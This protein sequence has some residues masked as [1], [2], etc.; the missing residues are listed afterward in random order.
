[1]RGKNKLG[2]VILQLI[3]KWKRMKSCR[4]RKK[5]YYVV[6]GKETKKKKKNENQTE[7]NQIK[8]TGRSKNKCKCRR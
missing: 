8:E 3:E 1:M 6:L 5:E 2:M 7:K 4:K